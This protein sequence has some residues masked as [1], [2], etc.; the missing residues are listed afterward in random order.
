M[1]RRNGSSTFVFDPCPLTNTSLFQPW[2]ISDRAMSYSAS[3]SV[4]ARSVIVPTPDAVSRMCCGEY[5]AQNGGAYGT[6]ALTAARRA[7]SRAVIVSVPSGRCAPCC[8]HDPI[9][10]STMSE[11]SWNQ[12]MSGGVRSSRLWNSGGIHGLLDEGQVPLGDEVGECGVVDVGVDRF[13]GDAGRQRLAQ[14]VEE[15]PVGRGIP[16]VAALGVGERE[17]AR[18]REHPHRPASL[19]EA[20]R[21]HPPE[22]VLLV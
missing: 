6:S 1:R 22:R 13:E 16:E 2:W 9:G 21:D 19:V 17:A 15:R 14:R 5:P 12:A 8:S 7:T 3:L 10:I 4:D 18:R 11:R 20:F